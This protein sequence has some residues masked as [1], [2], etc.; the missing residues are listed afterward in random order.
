MV[1]ASYFYPTLNSHVYTIRPTCVLIMLYDIILPEPSTFFFALCD[2]WLC[3]L[4]WL[5]MWQCDLCH[6][7]LTLVLKI[8]NKSKMKMKKKIKIKM[9]RKNKNKVHL[10]WSWQVIDS[11]CRRSEEVVGSCFRKGMTKN[12]YNG[13]KLKKGIRVVY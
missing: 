11:Y 8:E 1:H 13:L 12:F 2:L 5:V 7:T 9:K 10:Q 3:H 6:L 4:M